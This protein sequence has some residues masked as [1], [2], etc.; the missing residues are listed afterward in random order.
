MRVS[1][2][3]APHIADDFSTVFFGIREAKPKPAETMANREGAPRSIVQAG[4]PGEGGTRNQPRVDPDDETPTLVL[5]H[6]KD[7]R[8]QSQQLV[9]EQADRTYS[10]LVEYRFADNKFVRLSDDA[11]R[12]VTL[13]PHDH[14]AYGIDS[15]DYDQRASYDG[16]RYADIYALDLRTGARTLALVHARPSWRVSL[17]LHKILRIP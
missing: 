3:R 1:A 4:A 16:R 5:W 14:Y 10:Y 11:L 15:R 13:L 7:P 2:D 6:W 9:Q 12:Q 8:L 17:Q